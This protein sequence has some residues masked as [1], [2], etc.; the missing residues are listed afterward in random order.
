V[1][2]FLARIPP[3]E[4]ALIG[5]AIVVLVTLAVLSQQQEQQSPIDSYSTYD[6]ASGGYRALYETLQR[7]GVGVDR[8]ERQVG[9][10]DG[11]VETLVYAEPLPFDQRQ[12]PASPADAK[13]IEAWVR[14]GGRFVY[15]GHDDAAAKAKV[16]SLPFSRPA[17][18]GPRT[19]VVAPSL[20]AA[21]VADIG[22]LSSPL[23]WKLPHPHTE[24]LLGDGRG[25]AIVRYPFGRGTVTAIIDE[26]LFDNANLGHG[27][28]ARLAYALIAPATRGGTVWFDETVHGYLTPMHWWSIV[29]VPFVVAIAVAVVALLVGLAG[30]AVR[31]GPP[32]VPRSRDDRTSADFIDALSTLLERGGAARA[33]MQDA[34]RSTARTIARSLG[35]QSD[36][37]ADEIAERIENA[38]DRD[39]FRGLVRLAGRGSTEGA[40]FVRTVSLAQRLRKEFEPHGRQR[41]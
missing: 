15:I 41:Y 34:E 38:D 25:T 30:A 12:I 37:P 28:R 6:S 24:T 18:S 11:S 26:T 23:R 13:T 2:R 16:L 3:L 29:P 31:L 8:F 5:L 20:Q 14:A 35:M 27:D 39:A 36:A 40:N 21:G 33:A 32:L 19:V 7:L 10:L 1:R 22:V 4:T 17:G 9:L